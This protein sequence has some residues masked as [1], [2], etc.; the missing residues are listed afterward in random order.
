MAN[1]LKTLQ[2]PPLA[3][4]CQCVPHAERYGLTRVRWL[5]E[6]VEDS[7]HALQHGLK[8][9]VVGHARAYRYELGRA[10]RETARETSSAQVGRS[11]RGGLSLR[12][13][14]GCSIDLW[15]GRCMRR[16][17]TSACLTRRTRRPRA[18]ARRWRVGR[19]EG[20][21]ELEEAAIAIVAAT[22]AMIVRGNIYEVLWC[23]FSDGDAYAP[24]ARPSR[25]S[26]ARALIDLRKGV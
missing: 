18:S 8:L 16:S 10:R 23:V 22:L 13:Y 26:R 6:L 25:A 17:K 4:A 9:L 12:E 3:V 24:W 14:R 1:E 21:F 7:S 15:G 2:P 5:V 11:L 20:I 19:T